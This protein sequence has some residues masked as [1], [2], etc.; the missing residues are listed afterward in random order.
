MRKLLLAFIVLAALW[1]ASVAAQA[2]PLSPSIHGPLTAV[3]LTLSKPSVTAGSGVGMT[4][5]DTGSTRRQTYKLV[6]ASTAFV[7]AAV[8]CDLT[9]AT[10]P[11][12]TF[13]SY[14]I[15]N[16]STT[17]ACASV[18]TSGTLSMTAGAVSAAD[19]GF[20][21]SFDADL[22]TDLFGDA[23]A[24]L[25]TRINR[26]NA[27]QGGWL[28]SFS[29]TNIVTIRLTSGTGNIGTGAATNLSQGSITFYLTTEVLP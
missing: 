19:A 13:V 14:F 22:A 4:V 10:L 21:V 7:C 28:S 26:A 1:P 2:G 29:S 17:F 16:L 5:L 25:G 18:C 12:A 27:V 11:A 6:V 23:D 3:S 15:G 9:L 24:E 20:L 8:T